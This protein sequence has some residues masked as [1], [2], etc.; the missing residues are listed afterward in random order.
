MCVL[1]KFQICNGCVLRGI[2][3]KQNVKE[4]KNHQD[5]FRQHSKTP[6]TLLVLGNPICL[7]DL[8]T[9]NNQSGSSLYSNQWQ[10]QSVVPLLCYCPFSPTLSLKKTFHILFEC[11]DDTCLSLENESLVQSIIW[12]LQINEL[13][14]P[15]KPWTR[16]C[17]E[18]LK[19]R[20]K[21]ITS[22]LLIYN[23]LEKQVYCH[24]IS[25]VQ[26]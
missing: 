4:C 22:S 23:I 8:V 20:E 13:L 24:I 6:C 12:I 19:D 16:Y 26:D 1:L 21:H 14:L 25:I 2:T 9:L 5:I 7:L 3:W 10:E 17:G 18:F 11:T 15:A